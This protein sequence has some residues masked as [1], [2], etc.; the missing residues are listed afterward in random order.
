[1]DWKGRTQWKVKREHNGREKKCNRRS[2]NAYE[3]D[4]RLE[5]NGSE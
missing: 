5:S 2:E 4:L 3:R 1:M